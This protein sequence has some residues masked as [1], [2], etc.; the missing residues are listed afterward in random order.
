M[1]K[2]TPQTNIGVN[3]WYETKLHGSNTVYC[4][5]D[6]SLQCWSDVFFPLN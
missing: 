1:N 6:H 2:K 5:T 3:G 4:H